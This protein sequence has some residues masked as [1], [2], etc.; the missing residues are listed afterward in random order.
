MTRQVTLDVLRQH[1][2]RVRAAELELDEARQ[3]RDEVIRDLR[4]NSAHTVSEIAE[5]GGV[6]LAT[7]KT[8]LRGISR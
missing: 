5:A 4:R 8:V 2:A 6:S 7:A 3:A 1:A